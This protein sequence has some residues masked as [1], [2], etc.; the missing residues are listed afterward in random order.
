MKAIAMLH[1]I[2][3]LQESPSIGE[4]EN[5]GIKPFALDSNE[6]CAKHQRAQNIS[7]LMCFKSDHLQKST[8]FG[9]H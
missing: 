4:V 7:C 8:P 5:N 1:L 6:P 2:H 3:I 9:E